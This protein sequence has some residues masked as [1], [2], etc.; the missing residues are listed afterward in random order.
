MKATTLMQNSIKLDDQSR[1]K[2]GRELQNSYMRPASS[3]ASDEIEHDGELQAEQSCPGDELPKLRREREID[4]GELESLRTRWKMRESTRQHCTREALSNI[5]SIYRAITKDKYAIVTDGTRIWPDH[6]WEHVDRVLLGHSNEI[7]YGWTVG[8]PIKGSASIYLHT[9]SELPKAINKIIGYIKKFRNR[10]IAG[11]HAKN[12]S[13]IGEHLFVLQ[14]VIDVGA[15][16]GYGPSVNEE[17]LRPLKIPREYVISSH[18]GWAHTENNAC[19]LVEQ[20]RLARGIFESQ[21]TRGYGN[22]TWKA[23]YS[24]CL[25]LEG[26]RL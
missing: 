8:F 13:K 20:A 22:I 11:P 12:R 5:H 17:V 18:E 3:G 25:E 9:S 1:L 15:W 19:L 2:L 16:A 23:E 24:S 10:L 7:Q 6:I 21:I 4:M 14:W 26:E